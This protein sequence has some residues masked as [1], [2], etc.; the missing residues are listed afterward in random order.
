MA[1]TLS[2]GTT[3]VAFLID[4]VWLDE[5]AFQ[6]VAAA[7]GRGAHGAL[8]IDELAL[9]GG[10]PMTLE[11][12]V[13]RPVLQQIETWRAVA[14]QALTLDYRGVEYDVVLNHAAGALQAA[15]WPETYSDPD[16]TCMYDLTL[17]LLQV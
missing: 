11:T 10:R 2:D 13:M 16:D 1:T 15:G 6:P 8:F 9:T 4:P 3:T 7:V 14:G 17:R 5:H 12:L